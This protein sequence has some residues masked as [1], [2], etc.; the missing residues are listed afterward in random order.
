[1]SPRR[2]RR[3]VSPELQAR[4]ADAEASFQA[5]LDDS[6]LPFLYATQN[7]QSVPK[8]FKGQLK[9]PDYLVA[10]PFVG[11]IAVDVKA[12]SF[13]EGGLIFDV[14]EI[15]K[16]AKFDE[17][18]RIT[19]FLACVDPDNPTRTWWYRIGALTA[20]PP[21]RRMGAMTIHVSISDGL[22]ADMTRPLQEMLRDLLLLT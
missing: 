21:V 1:M 18:F 19:T 10:F 6:R 14:S 8:H 17:I 3:Q 4:G 9:R 12:K 20:R 13:Y 11:M 22:E 2:F 15:D 5:W 7:Q 16:L